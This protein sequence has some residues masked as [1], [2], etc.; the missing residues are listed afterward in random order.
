MIVKD[1]G[2][3]GILPLKNRGKSEMENVLK[4]LA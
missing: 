3:S 4:A 2:W 1:S